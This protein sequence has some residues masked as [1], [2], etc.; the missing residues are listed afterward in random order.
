MSD[1]TF[2]EK[3]KFEKLLGM[4]TGYV[5]NYSNRTFAEF[6]TDSTGCDI[7]DSRYDNGSGSKANRLRAFWKKEDNHLVG[8]LM[9]DM[10]DDIDEPSPDIETCRLIVKRLLGQLG[11]SQNQAHAPAHQPMQS[12]QPSPQQRIS[13]ALVELKEEFVHLTA[14]TDRNKAGLAFE[15]FLNRL[16]DTFQLKPRLP[17]RVVGEQIDGSFE[18]DSQIYLLELK[19]ENHPLPE[20]PL[21]AFRGKIEG[22]STFTRGM[23]VAVNGINFQARDAITRGKQPSFSS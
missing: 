2:A 5:L 4:G 17:F 10:F 15:S 23:F 9:T 18:L 19:W 12:S 3:R 21:L 20:A 7:Y 11:P 16:F 22:K 1:L 13:R 6:V 14:E 8:K